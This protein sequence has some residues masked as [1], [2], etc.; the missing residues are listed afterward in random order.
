MAATMVVLKKEV[1]H[2]AGKPVR[3]WAM[4]H[5]L[6]GRKSMKRVS[7][8]EAVRIFQLRCGEE[9]QFDLR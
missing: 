3:V 1:E 6:H 7:G 9:L 5:P 8:A 4:Y 2:P